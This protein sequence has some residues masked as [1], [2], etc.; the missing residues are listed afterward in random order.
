VRVLFLTCHVPYPPVSGGRRREYELLTRLGDR[1]EV[2]LCAVTKTYEEDV[3]YAGALR[4]FCAGVQVFRAAGDAARSRDSVP[5]Q[6]LRHE[7]VEAAAYV[8]NLVRRG[9]IDAVHL[10]GF[11]LAQHVPARAGLPTLLVEQNVEH[12]L[13]CQRADAT[14]DA[15][16]RQRLLQEWWRTRAA[17]VRAWRQSSL[18]AALTDEDRAGMLEDA[19]ELEVRIVPDGADHVSTIPPAPRRPLS[20]DSQRPLLV[21]VGNFGYEPNL[22]AALSLCREIM[23]RVRE[24]IPAARLL[25]VGNGPPAE[26]TAAARASG[27]VAVTGRVAAVEPFVDAADVVICPLRIGGGVK[28][29]MLEALAHGKAIVTTPIGVQGLGPQAFDCVRIAH[30][31]DAFAAA[32]VDLLVRPAERLRLAARARAFAAELPTWDEA[33]EALLGCYEELREAEQPAATSRR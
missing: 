33:A 20:Q 19:P 1:V 26:L 4:H 2:H 21:F 9:R 31:P 25:L 11:Y 15:S 24:R 6:V 7:S 3:V 18:C 5:L 10:E 23:P 22:D 28:V 12:R 32:T 16:S 17:E 29:K 14:T 8:G 27:C 30:D 13:W